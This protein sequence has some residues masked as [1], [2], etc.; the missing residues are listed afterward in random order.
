MKLF[1]IHIA[2]LL[3]LAAGAYAQDQKPEQKPDKAPA[4]EENKSDEKFKSLKED[5][6]IDNAEE[7][8]FIDRNGDGINDRV[9]PANR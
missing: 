7:K 3:A 8:K 4:A 1:I 9:Q 6:I 2:I 5:E